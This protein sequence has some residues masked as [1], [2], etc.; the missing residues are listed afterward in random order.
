MDNLSRLPAILKRRAIP[1]TAT[2]VAAVAVGFT[3]ALT[4]KPMY[5]TLSA[6]SGRRSNGQPV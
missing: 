4:S 5:R 1:A 2:L 3:Y 6:A